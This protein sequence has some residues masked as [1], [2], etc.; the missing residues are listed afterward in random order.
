MRMGAEV[1]PPL[2]LSTPLH[3]ACLK[4]SLDCT[5]LLIKAGA[6]L[7]ANDCHFGTPL[8]AATVMDHPACVKLLLQAGAFVNATKI[9][10]TALHIAAREDYVEVARVL[11]E[12]GANVFASNN[13]NKLPIDLVREADGQ[14][15]ELLVLHSAK[16]ALLKDLCRRK[17]RSILG[18]QRL[19]FLKDLELPRSVILYLMHLD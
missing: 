8:H 6:R 18:S 11:I 10:E 1:N 2:A 13:Q 4:G 19:K 5:A 3:E 9:H 15:Y 17:V 14:I 16:P 7:N 12:F